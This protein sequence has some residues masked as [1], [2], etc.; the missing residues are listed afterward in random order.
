MGCKCTPLTFV[1]ICHPYVIHLL[2]YLAEIYNI[3]RRL[4][5]A[6]QNDVI[7]SLLG[8]DVMTWR[9]DVKNAKVTHFYSV[10]FRSDRNVILNVF[11]T[12]SCVKEVFYDTRKCNKHFRNHVVNGEHL[13]PI[14]TRT[15]YENIWNDMTLN[16][17]VN[18]E[19]HAFDNAIFVFTELRNIRF[20]IIFIKILTTIM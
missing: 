20:D 17:K 2:R 19:G 8:H 6:L 11:I 14:G 16:F 1:S 5:H 13:H 3:I 7:L 4:Y 15:L 9:H 18:G 10:T 12:F